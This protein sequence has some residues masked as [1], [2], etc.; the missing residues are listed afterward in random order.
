MAA[1]TARF[2]VRT[3]IGGLKLEDLAL[4][5]GEWRFLDEAQLGLLSAKADI[6]R[7]G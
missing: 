6:S 1:S 3:A 2:E 7:S 5:E 4:P